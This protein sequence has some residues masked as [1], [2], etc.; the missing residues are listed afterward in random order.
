MTKKVTKKYPT[1]LLECLHCGEIKEIPQKVGHKTSVC[2]DCQRAR[3]RE[4]ARIQAEKEGR[5]AG[6]MGRLPYPLGE[7][8][9]Y[10][11]KFYKTRSIMSKIKDRDKW[12]EQI[13]KNLEETE[14]NEELMAW[15]NSHKEKDKGNKIQGKINKDYPDTRN[16]TWEDWEK[17]GYGMEEDD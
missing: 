11:Q 12:I 14:N 16:M 8:E 7:W 3:Q 6:L 2:L 17:L 10:Q 1:L 9:Y 15:I 13:K 4:Y 5:R